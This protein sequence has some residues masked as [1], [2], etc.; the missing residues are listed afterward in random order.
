[1]TSSKIRVNFS[2]FLKDVIPYFNCVKFPKDVKVRALKCPWKS[3]E[4][5]QEIFQPIIIDNLFASD[6]NRKQKRIFSGIFI[7]TKNLLRSVRTVLLLS[8]NY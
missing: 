7:K 6:K 1:M 5:N 4:V 8:D 3:L 2:N